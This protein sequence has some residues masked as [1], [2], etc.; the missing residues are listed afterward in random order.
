[1]LNFIINYFIYIYF[2]FSITLFK[3]INDCII[4]DI[5]FYNSEKPIA[6]KFIFINIIDDLL[7]MILIK[8]QYY[9]LTSFMLTQENYENQLLMLTH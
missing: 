4:F 5:F 9:H 8:Q 1:M 6:I 2:T 3:I 7:Y